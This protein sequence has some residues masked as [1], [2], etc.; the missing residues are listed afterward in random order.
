MYPVCQTA[1]EL[2]VDI[3]GIIVSLPYF[4]SVASI[5]F[6][7]QNHIYETQET[8]SVNGLSLFSLLTFGFCS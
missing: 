7:H 5:H 4:A 3:P 2:L 8:F 6:Y 1:F